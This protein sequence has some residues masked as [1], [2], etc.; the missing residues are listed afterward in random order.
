VKAIAALFV[1]ALVTSCALFEDSLNIPEYARN[2]HA[3]LQCDGHPQDVGGEVGDVVP[4]ESEGTAA[5]GP[6]IY[7]LRDVDLP[8]EGYVEAPVVPW[9]TGKAAYVRFVATNV[10]RVKAVVVMR[11]HSQENA[12]GDWRVVA[13]R[14]CTGNEFD[15]AQG[16]TIDNAPWVDVNGDVAADVSAFAGS[17]HCGWQST[18]W[19]RYNGRL[20]IRDPLAVL[21]GVTVAPFV[22]DAK[23][24][25]D[26]QPTGYRSPGRE[27]LASTSQQQFVWVRTS[28][29]L[30]R[31][32]GVSVDPGCA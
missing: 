1:I 17:A 2:L 11:G 26:L 20:Y 25:P 30:E 22:R 19:L 12:N 21:A 14:A 28:E 31:W 23:A 10:G 13:Y 27:L 9:G 32:S 18:L 29:G 6:W 3:Q 8:L 16:R 7:S 4:S 15:P 5:P 24:P